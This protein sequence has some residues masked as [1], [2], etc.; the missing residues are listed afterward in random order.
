MM[1]RRAVLGSM[2]AGAGA[3]TG[4]L[5]PAGAAKAKLPVKGAIG[6]QL[7]SLREHF[8]KDIP[9]TLAKVRNLGFENVE[10]AGT[11]DKKPD[12]LAAMLKKAK[13]APRAAHFPFERLRDD[14]P[15]AVTDAKALGVGFLVCPWIPHKGKYS[16]QDN[17]SAIAVFS[18]AGKA[19]KEAGM[20]FA[21]HIHGYEFEA[22]PDGTLFDSLVKKTSPDEVVFE[23][24][25]FCVRRGGEDPV[26]LLDRYPGRFPL[27]HLK[28]IAKGLE[29]C[30]PNGG[31][32]DTS[33]VPLGAGMI[34]WPGVLRAAEKNGTELYF[35]EDEHPDALKQIPQSLKYLA[36]IKL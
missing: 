33:S 30:A 28:D 32:P 2:V 11:Y 29:I 4:G 5:R 9:G 13:L 27:M 16:A 19:A 14:L 17:A 3:L 25:I 23:A 31:A 12:E 8:K 34:D 20:R 15:G 6:L 26:K 1:S 10:L 35:I 24:D 36:Q 21:Y 18:K 7:Y 22:G